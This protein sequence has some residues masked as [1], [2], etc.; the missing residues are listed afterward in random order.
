MK[1]IFNTLT[2]I[3]TQLVELLTLK[4]IELR[5][6]MIEMFKA[7][8]TDED[9]RRKDRLRMVYALERLQDLEKDQDPPFGRR[10]YQQLI[11][12][13]L[14]V[15]DEDIRN[16]KNQQGEDGLEERYLLDEVYTSEADLSGLTKHRKPKKEKQAPIVGKQNPQFG[17]IIVPT[18]PNGPVTILGI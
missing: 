4:P 15:L 3:D 2:N 8:S 10:E 14:K 1:E 7:V 5:V 11:D 12:E 17:N 9:E 6:K 13:A 16:I 18:V